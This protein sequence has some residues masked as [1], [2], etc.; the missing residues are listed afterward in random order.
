MTN[1]TADASRDWLSSERTNLL[2]RWIPL[3]ALDLCLP[4]SLR[5]AGWVIGVSTGEGAKYCLGVPPESVRPPA[6]KALVG[7]NE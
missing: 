3:G 7:D 4:V 6:V 1:S 2:G 5:T